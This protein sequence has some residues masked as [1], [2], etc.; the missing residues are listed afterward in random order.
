MNTIPVHS[1]KGALAGFK[2]EDGSFW[3]KEG[4]KVGQFHDE[5]LY[6]C[7]GSYSGEMINGRVCIDP[8]KHRWQKYGFQVSKRPGFERVPGR[9]PAPIPAGYKDFNLNE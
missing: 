2:K 9:E 1:H 3:S 7:K 8:R 4:I 6:N 5:L